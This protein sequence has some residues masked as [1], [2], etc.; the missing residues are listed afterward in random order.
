MIFYF[1]KKNTFPGG[2]LSN[3]I[4]EIVH[5]SFQGVLGISVGSSVLSSRKNSLRKMDTVL[6]DAGI[7]GGC[8]R[9]PLLGS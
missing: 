3:Q 7:F 2:I 1:A 6:E 9:H 5:E 8:A 4:E